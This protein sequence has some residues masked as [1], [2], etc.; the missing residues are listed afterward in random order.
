[1]VLSGL[2]QLRKGYR[3]K[4]PKD[5][6]T[7]AWL[8][9]MQ[10]ALRYNRIT[11]SAHALGVQPRTLRA[12]LKRKPELAK[13]VVQ[14]RRDRI[15][16]LEQR[17][18]VELPALFYN[19]IRNIERELA[20]LQASWL[21]QTVELWQSESKRCSGVNAWAVFLRGVKVFVGSAEMVPCSTA[22]SCGGRV[23][24]VATQS[25]RLRVVVPAEHALVRRAHVVSVT[26]DA[27]EQL[28]VL[29]VPALLFSAVSPEEAIVPLR[30][31]AVV[32]VWFLEQKEER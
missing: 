21:L 3:M 6:D 17:L 24:T 31:G 26:V 9:V 23:E 11:L 1:M 27:Q 14:V 5:T 15:A 25:G 20:D 18:R 7:D 10:E 19:E 12:W 22:H 2:Y 8:H 30:A 13:H 32:R 4:R 28:A 29:S 16:Y